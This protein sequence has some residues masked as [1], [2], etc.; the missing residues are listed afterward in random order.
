MNGDQLIAIIMAIRLA[1]HDVP[2]VLRGGKPVGRLDPDLVRQEALIADEI[3]RATQDVYFPETKQPVSA[4]T[5]FR[6]GL[7]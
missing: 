3:L 7:R 6:P 5:P 2:L 1:R 4:A